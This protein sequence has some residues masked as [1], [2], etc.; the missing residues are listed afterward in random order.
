MRSYGKSGVVERI[1]AAGG[2]VYGVTSE[3]QELADLALG[4]SHGDAVAAVVLA[5]LADGLRFVPVASLV[6]P[7]MRA[8]MVAEPAGPIIPYRVRPRHVP[9]ISPNDKPTE[10]TPPKLEK[11]PL[12]PV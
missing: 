8:A 9:V 10:D 7:S 2:E 3:P 5:L 6:P 1:R 11:E 4:S 12:P